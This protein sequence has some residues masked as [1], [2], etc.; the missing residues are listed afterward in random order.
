MLMKSQLVTELH[1]CVQPDFL[2]ITFL[3]D[4]SPHQNL[5]PIAAFNAESTAAG[6]LCS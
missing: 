6:P 3:P 5:H 2:G 4:E 1:V